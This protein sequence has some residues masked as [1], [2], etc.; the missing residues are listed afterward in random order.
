MILLIFNWFTVGCIITC[1]VFFITEISNVPVKFN[2][3]INVQQSNERENQILDSLN[4]QGTL[5]SE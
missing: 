5:D 2:Y 3:V 4:N 1:T